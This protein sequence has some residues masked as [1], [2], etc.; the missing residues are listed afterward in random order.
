M[1]DDRLNF[2]N[3][4]FYV[5]EEILNILERFSEMTAT[6]QSETMTTI[7]MVVPS[8]V[9]IIDHLKQISIRVI[10]F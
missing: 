3:T 2:N 9:H 7:S 10:Y 8:I 4:D 1:G 6:C 5:F